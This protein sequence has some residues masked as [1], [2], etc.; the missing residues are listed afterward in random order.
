MPRMTVD[1]RWPDFSPGEMSSGGS[2]D[3]SGFNMDPDFMDVL[4]AVRVFVDKPFRINSAFRTPVWNRHVG[5]SKNSMHLKGRA[6][7]IHCPDDAF[8]AKLLQTVFNCDLIGG[9]GI[10]PT[11]VHID[12]RSDP[13]GEKVVWYG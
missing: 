13:Q 4:Q 12:D 7:D 8:T 6:A 5:G 11:F 10:Y 9:V 2:G 3:T 1:W